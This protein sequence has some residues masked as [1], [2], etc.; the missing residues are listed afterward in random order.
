MRIT[1]VMTQRG[2]QVEEVCAYLGASGL[3]DHPELVYG[4]ARVPDLISPSR[5][6][7][8]KYVEWD[9]VHA[10]DREL[11]PA[12]PAEPN[13]GCADLKSKQRYVDRGVGERRPLDEDLALDVLSRAGLGP[14][15]T[16]GIARDVGFGKRAAGTTTNGP[17]RSP[18]SCAASTCW[19]A[20]G[21]RRRPRST[22]RWRPT[23]Q[24]CRGNWARNLPAA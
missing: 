7:A 13:R 23:I 24:R 6:G 5:I 17:R 21:R 3:A 19:S 14:R 20:A 11:S 8:D 2:T 1:R 22:R 15:Q 12:E 18:R 16:L 10:A 4:A 9:I